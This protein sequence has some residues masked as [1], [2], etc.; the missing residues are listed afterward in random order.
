MIYVSDSEHLFNYHVSNMVN[1]PNVCLH[2]TLLSLKQIWPAV[3]NYC[4]FA[5]TSSFTVTHIHVF[6]VA[7]GEA[8][9]GEEL[10]QC[11]TCKRCFFPKVLVRNYHL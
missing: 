5:Y 4:S 2:M 6:V 11:N 1:N 3:V 9:S 8:P 7:D 10:I